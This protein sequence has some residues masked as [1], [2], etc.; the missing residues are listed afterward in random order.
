M[1][2]NFCKYL[3]HQRHFVYGQM[4]PCCWFSK[5]VDLADSDEINLYNQWLGSINDWVPEC[6]FCYIKEEKNNISPRKQAHRIITDDYDPGEIVK[7][8]IQIDRDCNGACLMCGP[9]NSTSWGK[10]NSKLRNI[11]IDVYLDNE[12]NVKKYLKQINN[13][14]NYGSVLNVSFSGGEPFRSETHLEILNEIKKVKP[15]DNV[16]VNYITNGSIMPSDEIFAVWQEVKCVNLIVSI[17]AIEDHFN[18][19]RYP[20]QWNQVKDNLSALLEL[21]ISNICIDSSYTLTPFNMFYH[22]RYV[23][24]ANDF[25]LNTQFKG[26]PFFSQPFSANGILNIS[27]TPE[28]LQ[29]LIRTKYQ[30]SIPRGHSVASCLQPYNPTSYQTFIDY[31]TEQDRQRGTDWRTVFPEI[32][33]YF[34]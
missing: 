30:G 21:N 15:L 26:Q 3:S 12:L 13:N 16:I 23:T 9:D 5:S 33:P 34:T 2:S 22:D 32:V 8:E 19:L 17:D 28:R 20:L 14:I 29:D 10:Y 25:F 1:T 11:G 4:K 18:Y 24:W 31:I 6:G 7:I 27:A